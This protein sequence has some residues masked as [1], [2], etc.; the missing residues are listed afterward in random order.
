M[1][2]N[3]ISK[4][5]K[6]LLA[7]IIR[8]KNTKQKTKIPPVQIK[9]R[10]GNPLSVLEKQPILSALKLQLNCSN[11][12]LSGEQRAVGALRRVFLPA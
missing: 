6:K 8:E 7:K 12:R 10:S 5:R 2:S 3:G 9:L 11:S 4:E 1:T